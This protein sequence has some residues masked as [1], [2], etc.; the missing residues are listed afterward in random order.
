MAIAAQENRVLMSDGTDMCCSA[1]LFICAVQEYVEY[2]AYR[3]QYV[4]SD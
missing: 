3:R 1:Y 4:L 2:A